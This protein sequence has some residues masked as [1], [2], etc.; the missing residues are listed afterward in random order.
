MNYILHNAHIITMDDAAEYRNMD[1]LVANGKI[2]RIAPHIEPYGLPVKDCTGKHLIP[3][4]IDCHIHMD[5]SEITEMLLACGITSC[6]NM[7]G[8][9]ETQQWRKEI[10]TGKRFGSRVYSTGPLIDGVT[11]WEGSLVVTTPQEAEKA[12]V[13]TVNNGYEFVKTY[14]SI[15]R[16]AFLH[17]MEVACNLGIKVVGHGNYSVSFKELVDLGYYSLEHSSCLPQQDE[18]ILM[19]AESGIWF[20]PTLVVGRTIE[21]YV[22]KDGDLRSTKNF[23]SMCQ[24][25]QKDW[26]KVTAWRKSLHRYDNLDYE[27]EL[28]RAR[29]FVA[30]SDRI[31]LGT[32]VPNPGVTGGHSVY[33]ELELMSG[34]FGMSPYRVLRTAT[35]NAASCIGIG[36]QKGRLKEGMDAD[37]LVLNE[38]PMLDIKNAGTYCGVI[39]EGAWYDRAEMDSVLERVKH[40]SEEYIQPLM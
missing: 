19:V 9:P 8:F 28:N 14:P 31:L 2:A 32:D 34:V 25:W 13:D 29:L 6:R 27:A 1:L 39:K 38:D 3:G 12:V 17:L 37:I 24:Y 16:E 21:E 22:H 4:L 33:E 23:D 5:S 20:C 26:E 40:Y 36:G 18:E 30:H 7:W 15:P 11:Y 35:V 10:D